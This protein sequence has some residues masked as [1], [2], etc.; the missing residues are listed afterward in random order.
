MLATAVHALRKFT[1]RRSWRATACGVAAGA[2]SLTLFTSGGAAAV[3]VVPQHAVVGAAFAAGAVTISRASGP[4]AGGDEVELIGPSRYFVDIDYGGRHTLALDNAGDAYAWGFGTAGQL[5][6]GAAANQGVP[7]PVTMP[8]GVAFTQLAAGH[9]HSLALGSDGR[10][11]AWG[12]NVRGQLG[13]GAV[14]GSAS[15]PV[16]V[17]GML[18]GKTITKVFAGPATSFALDADGVLYSWGSNSVGQLGRQD[19]PIAGDAGAPGAVDLPPGVA[20]GFGY[21]MVSASKTG[22]AAADPNIHVLALGRDGRVYAWGGNLSERLGRSDVAPGDSV[23]VPGE[24]DRVTAVVPSTI[25]QVAAGPSATSFVVTDTGEAYSW[26]GQVQGNLATGSGSTMVVSTPGL[27]SIGCLSGREVTHIELGFNNAV[28]LMSDG[29]ACTW[30]LGDHGQNM[31]SGT[32]T[33]GTPKLVDAPGLPPGV[34]IAQVSLGISQTSQPGGTGFVLGSDGKVYVSGTRTANL[35]VLGVPAL[36]ANRGSDGNW[37]HNLSANFNYG[38]VH[39]GGVPLAAPTELTGGESAPGQTRITVLVPP[40]SRAEVGTTSGLTVDVVGSVRAFG[41]DGPA[42]G[43]AAGELAA[44]LQWQTVQ[45]TYWPFTPD[46]AVSVASSDGASG[47]GVAGATIVVADAGGTELCLTTV[48]AGG[49]W[50]CG[51]PTGA[52]APGDEIFVAQ[53]EPGEDRSGPSLPVAAVVLARSDVPT[54]EVPLLT[55]ASGTGEP[56]AEIRVRGP[57]ADGPLLCVAHVVGGGT[58]SCAYPD[59]SVLPGDALLATQSEAGKLESQA[60][61]TTV[62]EPLIIEETTVLRVSGTGEPDSLITGVARDSES[63]CADDPIRVAADGSWSCALRPEVP[64]GTTVTVTQIDPGNGAITGVQRTQTVGVAEALGAGGANENGMS[65]E[66]VFMGP[67][68]APML[69]AATLAAVLLGAGL[70]T[71]NRMAARR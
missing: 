14:G 63:A 38:S 16:E 28:A 70:I 50:S 51:F 34:T 62:L 53:S 11:F 21:E 26:G 58:W 61:R 44:A 68:S 25:V 9:S 1:S 13:N 10:V 4:A 6:N 57:G 37:H 30:G 22:S 3:A 7:V 67:E 52:V 32:W 12:D 24:A 60:V 15:A 56:G 23:S 31:A 49:A 48:L 43:S 20:P 8:G 64:P 29:A 46:P 39:W 47:A 71:A 18:A 27:R 69:W 2:V 35:H 17:A 45:Y 55:D 5:G 66:V 65:T 54:I 36:A 19:V 42:L 33:G 41:A 59:G 40:K